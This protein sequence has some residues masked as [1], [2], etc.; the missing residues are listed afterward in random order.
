MIKAGNTVCFRG[1]HVVE[2]PY[3]YIRTV[4]LVLAAAKNRL[5]DYKTPGKHVI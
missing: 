5:G 4:K 2:N 1:P 3:Y